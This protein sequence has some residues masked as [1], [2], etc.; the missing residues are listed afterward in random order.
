MYLASAPR[1]RHAIV[2]EILHYHNKVYMSKKL[3]S[4][5]NVHFTD[6]VL[7]FVIVLNNVN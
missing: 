6:S 1:T 2:T 3:S 5:H 4:K 7:Y